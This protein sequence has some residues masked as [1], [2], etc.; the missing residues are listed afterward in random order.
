MNKLEIKGNWNILKGSL[1]KK[2]A[3][4]TDDDLDYID[5]QRDELLGR[6]QKRTGES[7]ESVKATIKEY[8]D[9]LEAASKNAQ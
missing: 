7:Y 6:I 5:G 2:W 1:K 9:A 8:D 3:E 4:L